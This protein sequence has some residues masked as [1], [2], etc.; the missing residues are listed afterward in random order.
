MTYMTKCPAAGAVIYPPENTAS[1]YTRRARTWCFPSPTRIEAAD[2]IRYANSQSPALVQ[3]PHHGQVEEAGEEGSHTR[4][5][6]EGHG[7]G[8]EP[9]EGRL[10]QGVQEDHV[11]SLGPVQVDAAHRPR[12]GG[13]F[14]L[15]REC[16][17]FPMHYSIHIVYIFRPSG[18]LFG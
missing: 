1:E 8:Q 12:F 13:A 5:R 11:Q 15:P 18:R 17:F 3:G 2:E 16:R 6:E 7:L 14:P 10:Q 9:E 4:V